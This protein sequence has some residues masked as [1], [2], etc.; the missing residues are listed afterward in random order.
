MCITSLLQSPEAGLSRCPPVGG[1][2]TEL[3]RTHTVETTQRQKEMV[4]WYLQ[5]HEPQN[6]YIEVKKPDTKV[7]TAR[8]CLYE[9][10]DQ[11]RLICGEKLKMVVSS[12]G[13]GGSGLRRG[14]RELSF[15]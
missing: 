10:L 15:F 12:G 14:K 11:L 6:V 7:C 3:R 4:Y 8:F 1:W 13:E 9:V 2:L 5:Q